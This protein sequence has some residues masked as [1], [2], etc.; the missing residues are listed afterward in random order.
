MGYEMLIAILAA[1]IVAGTPLL[2]AALGEI[3]AERT[4]VLNLGIE[5]MMLVGAV[6]SFMVCVNTGS[7]WLG[8]VAGMV[9]GG[10]VAAIHAFLCITLKANQVVSGLALTIFGTG[11]SGFLGKALIGI[12]APNTFSKIS[13]PI[14]SK[15]PFFGPILFNQDMLV[16]I[17]YLLVPALWYFI[18]YTNP[19]LKMRSVG[20]NPGAADSLGINVFLIRYT[21]VI[22]GG[23]LSGIAGAYLA[24]AY[25]PTW[26][27][28]MTA[29]R[30]WIAVAL[31]IF[32]TWNPIKALIGAYI[33]GGVDALGYRLQAIGIDIPSYFLNMLP[34]LFTIA[35]LIFATQ[36][37]NKNRIGAPGALMI[38]YDR[39]DR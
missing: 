3:L 21:Y 26:L 5:G 35:V 6:T 27:E 11:L 9:F 16:Y 36:Q 20:E 7:H 23:V 15:I 24:L 38:S 31:V 37:T 1:A 25:A 12:P 8:L 29:G 30:G 2:Y 33:F 19:G 39:E 14:L 28:N 18:Y 17:S 34:Y 32:A 10:L 13:I 22:L 4:G